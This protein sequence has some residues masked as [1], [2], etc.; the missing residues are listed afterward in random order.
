MGAC[1]VSNEICFVL[2]FLHTSSEGYGSEQEM[3]VVSLQ[4][5]LIQDVGEAGQRH[6]LLREVRFS[7]TL[8]YLDVVARNESCF[9]IRFREPPT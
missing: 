9:A 1:P 4:A 5:L 3:G 6:L 8:N 2:V 7:V